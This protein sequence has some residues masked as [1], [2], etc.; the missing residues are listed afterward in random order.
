MSTVRVRFAPSPTGYLHVGSART[1]LFNWLF[2]RHM[3]GEFILR[4]E[5]TDKVRSKDE[6]LSEILESLKWLGLDWDGEP[7]FQSKR[8]SL[9]NSCAKKLLA[10]GHAYEKEDAL[11]F[12]MPVMKLKITDIIHGEIEFDTSLIKDQVLIK[13]DGSPTYNFAV[14]VDDS[15]M[16]I[17]HIIRGDDHISNTP[18]Q[19][20]IYNALGIKLPQFCHIPLILGVDRSR[21]SKRHGAT[22]IRDYREEGFLPEALVNYLCLLGWSPGT[23]K[24]IMPIDEVI[25]EFTLEHINKT[26]A[27]FDI[28][29]LMWVN[30]EYIKTMDP[31]KLTGLITE[32]L[33]KE[34][35]LK[36]GFDKN[37]LSEI[38]KL[39]KERIRTIYDFAD[40][41][42]YFFKDD[43][44]YDPDGIKKHFTPEAKGILQAVVPAFESL[45]QFDAA[46]LE[47]VVRSLADKLGVKAAKIIHPV[48]LAATGK[49]AG[50]GLFETLAILGKEK[51]IAR[52]KAALSK[53]FV[54]ID[55]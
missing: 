53:F 29:K 27:V 39:F 14:V 19:V 7:A 43:F 16:G 2:A 5:D 47:T 22:S 46:S 38:V 44:E 45:G 49:T 12:K 21:L 18:K 13:S 8:V 24:E 32:I 1:A 20:V 33:N 40:L 28:N 35:L 25:K 30:A 54:S 41:T 52:M 17:T 31:A 51:T 11:H 6:F 42:S 4:I 15:D 26:A 36:D 48:R 23:G 55:G 37:M 10:S 3:G 34:N 9:Y 50:A